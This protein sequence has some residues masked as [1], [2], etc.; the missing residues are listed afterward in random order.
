MI[1]LVLPP[2]IF[3]VR[4][5][6]KMSAELTNSQGEHPEGADLNDWKQQVRMYVGLRQNSEDTAEARQQN[7][8]TINIP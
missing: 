8:L 2:E 7:I 1:M 4:G 6:K 5:C 3:P